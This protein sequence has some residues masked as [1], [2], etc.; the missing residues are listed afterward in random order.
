MTELSI[1]VAN[2][3]YTDKSRPAEDFPPATAPNLPH[4]L[5]CL[6]SAVTVLVKM[7]EK[8]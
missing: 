7:R 4:E 1:S 3:Y 6:R 5:N 8:F 2:V